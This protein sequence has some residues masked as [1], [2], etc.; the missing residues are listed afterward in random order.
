MAWNWKNAAGGAGIGSALGSIFGGGGSNPADAASKYLNQI[1]GTLKPYYDPYI[2]SGKEAMGTL[3][4]Q[5]QSLINDPTGLMNAI[6]QNYQQSPGYQYNVD[7]ATSGANQAAAAGGMV[8]S[9]AEQ[10]ELAK[11]ISGISSQDYNNYL[12]TALGQYGMG[13]QGM[14]GIN[15][16]GYNASTGLGDNLASALMSQANL[17][18]AGQANQNQ[19]SGQRNSGFGAGLGALA[20]GFLF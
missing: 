5:Y 18:Y 13:M 11:R 19:Q 20:G 15:Q 6:G 16:M 4:P 1:P 9:P 17:A 2:N 10:E 14:Q 12:Q 8:G 3:M 7:Q